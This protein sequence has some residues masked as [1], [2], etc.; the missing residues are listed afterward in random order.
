MGCGCFVEVI[1]VYI[2]IEGPVQVRLVL[3]RG[4]VDVA[5]KVAV[6]NNVLE[7]WLLVKAFSDRF[8]SRDKPLP[9]L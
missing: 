6:R 2:G 4:L 1:R 8:F 5:N 3:R 9:T 7:G